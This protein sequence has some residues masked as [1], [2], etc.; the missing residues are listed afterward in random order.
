MIDMIDT[1]SMCGWASVCYPVDI[2][3][4]LSALVL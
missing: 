2:D 3:I 1:E 4:V